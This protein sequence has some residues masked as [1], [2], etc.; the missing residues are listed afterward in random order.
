MKNLIAIVLILL[1]IY[2]LVVHY[3]PLPFNHESFGLYNHM[4]HRIV[5]VI[6]LALGGYL[7]WL[8]KFKTK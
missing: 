4:I 6:L 1:G 5:G 8:W 3:A 2:W 7:V